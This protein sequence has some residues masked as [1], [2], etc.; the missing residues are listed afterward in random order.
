MSDVLDIS[1]KEIL[2]K[3]LKIEFIWIWLEISE[4]S[5]ISVGADFFI[6]KTV[7]PGRHLL[8]TLAHVLNYLSWC[9]IAEMLPAG[10]RSF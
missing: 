1:Y 3:F 2:S 10:W 7:N 9:H 4:I 6:S 5:P 8:L